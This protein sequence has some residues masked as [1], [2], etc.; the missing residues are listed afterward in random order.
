MISENSDDLFVGDP[1]L[2]E[3]SD[4]DDTYDE[5]E[6]DVIVEGEDD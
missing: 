5:D 1:D 3:A 6:G 2:A 4:Y